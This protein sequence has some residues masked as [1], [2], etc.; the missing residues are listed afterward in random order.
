MTALKAFSL[1]ERFAG[2]K[3]PHIE[4]TNLHHL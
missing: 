2:L 4:R 3:D 1:V